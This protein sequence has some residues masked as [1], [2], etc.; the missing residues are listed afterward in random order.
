MEKEASSQ[1]SYKKMVPS[2]VVS[3]M[4]DILNEKP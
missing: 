1:H 3:G 4:S 2:S